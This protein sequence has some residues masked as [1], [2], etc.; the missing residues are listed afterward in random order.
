MVQ[1][2]L[3]LP[4]QLGPWLVAGEQAGKAV[5]QR[6]CQPDPLNLGTQVGPL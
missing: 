6:C 5:M 2:H 1:L 3:L 4:C